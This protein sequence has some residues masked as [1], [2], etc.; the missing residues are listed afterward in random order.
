MMAPCWSTAVSV[1]TWRGIQ[2]TPAASRVSGPGSR[3][4]DWPASVR[5]SSHGKPL[6]KSYG[7]VTVMPMYI[8][9]DPVHTNWIRRYFVSITSCRVW[10]AV[11]QWRCFDQ[12]SNL[13]WL[14]YFRWPES[15]K[16]PREWFTIILPLRLYLNRYWLSIVPFSWWGTSCSIIHTWVGA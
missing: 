2:N 16:I 5:K 6:R 11:V 3:R 4:Q 12:D 9:M 7:H 13:Q 1:T 14:D 10:L 15:F 8:C